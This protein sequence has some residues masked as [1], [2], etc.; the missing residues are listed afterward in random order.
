MRLFLYYLYLCILVIT[1]VR[2][3]C[4]G[5]WNRYNFG[6]AFRVYGIENCTH[7]NHNGSDFHSRIYSCCYYLAVFDLG[8]EGYRVTTPT[9][10]ETM[11][12]WK[13]EDDYESG[14]P[15]KQHEFP[16]W[17]SNKEYLAYSSPSATF[18]GKEKKKKRKKEMKT[19]LNRFNCK[20]LIYYHKFRRSLHKRLTRMKTDRPSRQ[21]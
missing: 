11:L 3:F 10:T 17:C 5:I 13:R 12:P 9:A 2:L 15:I 20:I 18:L 4:Q 6:G 21:S 16:A 14:H 1:F 7:R 8:A 19:R